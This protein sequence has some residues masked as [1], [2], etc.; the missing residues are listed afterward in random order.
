MSEWKKEDVKA[1]VEE[2]VAAG[3]FTFPEDLAREI[4]K[5]LGVDI[6]G[7]PLAQDPEGESRTA[8]SVPPFSGPAND[9]SA[10]A[11]KEKG[12]TA[13]KTTVKKTTVTKGK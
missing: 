1:R 10:E 4:V 5:A 9:E 6:E 11:P 13:K 3:N 2:Q 12:T 8:G 7:T